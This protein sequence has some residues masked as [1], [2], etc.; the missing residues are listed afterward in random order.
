M[1]IKD[2]YIDKHNDFE[3][4]L[5]R[6]RIPRYRLWNKLVHFIVQNFFF[7]DLIVYSI[8]CHLIK[9][10]NDRDSRY[11]IK[12]IKIFNQNHKMDLS[13]N[14]L[15]ENFNLYCSSLSCLHLFLSLRL[16]L[17]FSDLHIVDFRPPYQYPV[18]ATPI[19]SQPNTPSLQEKHH[20]YQ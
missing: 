20:V 8:S 14:G 16:C 2:F 18:S 4:D 9:I 10:L 12:I 1:E 13:Q 11:T 3:P 15:S 17:L 6:Q 19:T 7:L 5:Y